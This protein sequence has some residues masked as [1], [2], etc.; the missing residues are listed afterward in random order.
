MEVSNNE[1]YS[2]QMLHYLI[3]QYHYQV[4]KLKQRTDSLSN[5]IWILN[6]DSPNYPIIC[7]SCKDRAAI[8]AEVEQLRSIHRTFLDAIHREGKL[9][10]VNVNPESVPFENAYLT[11]I[12]ANIQRISNPEMLRTFK[13]M[14]QV[15]HN[16][17]DR[18]DEIARL[19]REI[20]E[21]G[22]R[23][24]KMLIKRGK[25]KQRPT[26]T[27][28]TMGVCILLSLFAYGMIYLLQD[29]ATGLV[30]SGVYYKMNIIA[31]YE[32]W[33]L[34]TAGFIQS[35]PLV[36]VFHMFVLYQAGKLC[37]PFYKTWRYALI[38]LLS[39][40]VGNLFML[41][42][43]GNVIA[44][45]IGAGIFGVFGAYLVLIW[46]QRSYRGTLMKLRIWRIV[47][48]CAF[49][50]VMP[51]ISILAHFGGLLCGVTLALIFARPS[52]IPVGKQ[53][54]VISGCLLL[55][56]MISWVFANQ[57][58]DPIEKHLD[59]RILDV[60]RNTAMNRYGQY[61]QACYIRQYEKEGT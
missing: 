8:L 30:V 10:V 11:Q 3:K 60:Y 7:V 18:S 54:I 25:R 22:L 48:Y 13:G 53:H 38:L 39:I 12:C 55:A 58:V 9:L 14:D 31:A 15:I 59:Y 44:S 57:T 2:Y 5:E 24:R 27:Y 23:D 34:L 19:T 45:G 47:V 61:L 29:Y 50:C 20:D 26:F 52:Q 21:M 17:A 43:S 32:Y 28:V 6:V 51:G 46:Q 35:D 16:V 1:I 4:V 40:V 42:A 36:L 49:V 37:E 56:G 33:R 41:I